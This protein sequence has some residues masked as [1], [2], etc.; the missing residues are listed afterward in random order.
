MR[1]YIQMGFPM[2]AKTYCPYEWDGAGVVTDDISPL[3]TLVDLDELFDRLND[4]S[5]LLDA[6]T[7]RA[8]VLDFGAQSATDLAVVAERL[9]RLVHALGLRA[10]ACC[11]ASKAHAGT[12]ARNAAEHRATVAGLD[13][14]DAKRTQTTAEHLAGLA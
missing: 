12:G 2:K 1:S 3:G 10:A 7:Q 4:A 5:A 14:R 9:R 6:L 13:R 8:A 11:A